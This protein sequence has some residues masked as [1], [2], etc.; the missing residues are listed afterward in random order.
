ML[1]K[2]EYSVSLP[3]KGFNFQEAKT[4]L[5]E[6]S[7][8]F[9]YDPWQVKPEYKNTI[10]ENLLKSLPVDQGE[11]RVIKLDYGTTYMSHTDIDDRWHL[12]L[13]GERAYLID[14]DEEQMFLTYPDGN[15]YEMNAGRRHVASN[16]GSI[17]RYQLVVRK[18]LI[19]SRHTNLVN[20][21]IQPVEELFDTRY[22]FD[23]LI[24]P[25]LNTINKQGVMKDF[26]HDNQTVT[27]KIT[28]DAL[29]TFPKQKL[30]KAIT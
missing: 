26:T 1:H 7:G 17:H 29:A 28:T 19:E 16:Y 10:W 6:P 13:Q 11:A 5:N 9:F 12:T 21:K 4:T 8:R 24:S 18:L 23:N 20:V 25:W 3:S 15:W 2:T 22:Q 27:F 14:L 30:F